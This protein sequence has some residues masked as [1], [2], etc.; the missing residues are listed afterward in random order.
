MSRKMCP[1]SLTTAKM[2]TNLFAKAKTFNCHTL[3]AVIAVLDRLKPC[4]S[5]CGP[6]ILHVLGSYPQPLLWQSLVHDHFWRHLYAYQWKNH[7]QIPLE[8]GRKL[9]CQFIVITKLKVDICIRAW[10]IQDHV[11]IHLHRI[12]LSQNFWIWG[13]CH[14]CLLLLVPD[15]G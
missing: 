5:E 15:E 4:E 1:E 13:S 12:Q 9:N 2:L 11:Q 8:W 14:G 6:K 3:P 10:E 7:M